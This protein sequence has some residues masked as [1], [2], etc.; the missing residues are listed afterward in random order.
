MIIV[1]VITNSIIITSICSIYASL[2]AGGKGAGGRG[3]QGTYD[4]KAVQQ[5]RMERQQAYT[6]LYYNIIDYDKI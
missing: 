5:A 6:I 4:H 1:I 3:A 2:G